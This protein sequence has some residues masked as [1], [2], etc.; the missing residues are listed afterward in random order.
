VVSAN[1]MELPV[2]PSTT[3]NCCRYY[4]KGPKEG[5]WDMFINS[6]PGVVDNIIPSKKYGGFWVAI[7]MVN[8][9]VLL[10]FSSQWSLM[11]FLMA[12]VWLF[13]LYSFVSNAAFCDLTYRQQCNIIYTE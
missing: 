8:P 10:D 12:K 5:Q 13:V 4:L 3:C 2:I 9:N 7:P 1:V 6:V 11:Q